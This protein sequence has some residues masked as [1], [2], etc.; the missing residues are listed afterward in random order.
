MYQSAARMRDSG[1]LERRWARGGTAEEEVEEA[2]EIDAGD[3]H[4]F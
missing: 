2:Q 1:S 4:A 3:G